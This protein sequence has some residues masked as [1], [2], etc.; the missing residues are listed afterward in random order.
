MKILIADDDFL[1]RQM[2]E[3]LFIKWGYEVVTAANG[4]EAWKILESDNRPGMAILDRI[5]PGMEGTDICREFRKL[6]NSELTYIIL[7]TS[8][9][10]KADI[11]AGLDAGADDYITKP[12]N[13]EELRARVN[14]GRQMAELQSAL[15]DRVKKLEE[16]VT[17][18]KRL[19]NII[20][21]IC[22][23]CKKIRD[24]KNYWRQLESYF[25]IYSDVRFSHGICPECYEKYVKPE[26]D[27]ME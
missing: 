23:Y 10:N 7:L 14:V 19:Q 9:G 5:M 17:H 16:A 12:F 6:P 8:K 21:P 3:S 24:D 26:L 11:V 1:T 13:H 27:E 22:S 25:A 4:K 20:L 18:I 15:T 2:I